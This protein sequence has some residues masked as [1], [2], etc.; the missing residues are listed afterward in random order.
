MQATVVFLASKDFRDVI[1]LDGK[2]TSLKS[3]DARN[4]KF[5]HLQLLVMPAALVTP[6]VTL[7]FIFCKQIKN[8]P[9]FFTVV[10]RR[11]GKNVPIFFSVVLR[12][13]GNMSEC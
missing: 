11:I 4:N 12:R 5:T 10:L 1:F 8:V 3:F 6:N 2:M 9:I 7:K 13:I